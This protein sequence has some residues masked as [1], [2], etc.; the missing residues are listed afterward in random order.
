M[1]STS[2]AEMFP[3]HTPAAAQIFTTVLSHGPLTR[4]DA[5]RR[6]GLSTAAVTKA[7]VLLEAGGHLVE[8]ADA[9]TRTV[10]GRP[11]NLV[12]VDG[13]EEATFHRHRDHRRRDL[14]RA[15]RPVLPRPRRPGSPAAAPVSP[16]AVR[17]R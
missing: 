9:E 7:V 10:L 17:T 5:A 6:A 12:R 14:R 2:R 16:E 8:D 15:H 13:K 4:A 1:P 3:V 11:A